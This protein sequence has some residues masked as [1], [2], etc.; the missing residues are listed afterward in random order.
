MARVNGSRYGIPFRSRRVVK[1]YPLDNPSLK[2][3][4]T[5]NLKC[6]RWLERYSKGYKY[7]TTVVGIKGCA[8]GIHYVYVPWDCKRI[9][10]YDPINAIKCKQ[11][12]NITSSTRSTP[13]PMREFAFSI[14]VNSEAMKQ[15]YVIS[16]IWHQSSVFW[17]HDSNTMTNTIVGSLTTL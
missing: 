1:F 12:W 5:L 2:S 14:L 13:A 10:K 9:L 16:S 11:N 15:K 7:T 17:K 6:R 4:L 8:F 3:D